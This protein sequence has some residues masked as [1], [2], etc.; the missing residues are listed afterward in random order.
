MVPLGTLFDERQFPPVNCRRTLLG[1]KSV[2]FPYQM[3]EA[4]NLDW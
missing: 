2:T 4:A 3:L 1:E